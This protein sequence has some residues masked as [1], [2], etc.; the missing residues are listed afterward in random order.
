MLPIDEDEYGTYIMN[1]RDMCLL[2]YL[3]ELMDAGVISFK[4]EGRSKTINYLAGVGRAYRT[5]IDAIERGESYDDVALSK[6]I[7]AISNRGYTPGFL[8]GDPGAKGIYYEKNAELKEEDY[9]GMVKSYDPT[10]GLARLVVKNR[11][12]VGDVLRVISPTDSIEIVLQNI[13]N[14]AGE[15]LVSAHGG[16]FDV[17]IA[18]PKDMGEYAILRKSSAGMPK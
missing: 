12:D 16:S 17:W 13:Q 1:S 15:S 3:K 11:F 6:E 14:E 9:L 7:F 5:A 4:V 8:V 10:T 2:G 18:L